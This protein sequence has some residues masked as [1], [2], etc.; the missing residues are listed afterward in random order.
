MDR[1][2]IPFESKTIAFDLDQTAKHWHP[3]D[4]THDEVLD[5]GDF[6]LIAEVGGKRYELYD[7][8]T[9]AEEEL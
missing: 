9:F 2:S 5:L 3:I 6:P 8:G 4:A 7:D 1:V